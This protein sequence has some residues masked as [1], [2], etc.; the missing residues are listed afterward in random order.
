MI[1]KIHESSKVDEFI[2]TM[3]KK[4]PKKDRRYR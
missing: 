3:P 4:V 2:K 1:Y